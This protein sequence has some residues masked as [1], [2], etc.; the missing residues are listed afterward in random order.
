[1]DRALIFDL[2]GTLIDSATD[3]AQALNTLL[4]ERHRPPVTMAQMKTFI[5]DG[6][7]KLVER[8]FLASGGPDPVD[9]LPALTAQFVAIYESIPATPAQLYPDVAKTLAALSA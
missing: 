3:L 5:G 7:L 8:A 2:D 9:T 1:M 4:A 6:A